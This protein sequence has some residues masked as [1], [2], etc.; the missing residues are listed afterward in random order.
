MRKKSTGW[1]EKKDVPDGSGSTEK[2]CFAR[3]LVCSQYRQ[4]DGTKDGDTEKRRELTTSW[5][6]TRSRFVSEVRKTDAIPNLHC[7]WALFGLGM[8]WAFW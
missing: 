7:E 1:A 6:I 2:A 8:P 3:F 5:L 4:G